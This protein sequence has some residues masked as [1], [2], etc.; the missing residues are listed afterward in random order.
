MQCAW[1]NNDHV[2]DFM[3]TAVHFLLNTSSRLRFILVITF[4]ASRV[5]HAAQPFCT[6]GRKKFKKMSSN[7]KMPGKTEEG[8]VYYIYNC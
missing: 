7:P 8:F 1:V 6:T 3:K 4:F 5:S 2:T